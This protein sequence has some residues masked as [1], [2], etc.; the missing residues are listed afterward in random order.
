MAGELCRPEVS[1]QAGAG[2]ANLS[3]ALR[4]TPEIGQLL[5]AQ[6][7]PPPEAVNHTEPLRARDALV[8]HVPTAP[9]APQKG[10]QVKA[11]EAVDCLRQLALKGQATHLAVSDYG[12]TRLLLQKNG[13]VHGAVL[14]LFEVAAGY[15]A[16]GQLLT[17][18]QQIRRTQQTTDNVRL[19]V[20]HRALL[21][22]WC[23]SV[24]FA[25]ES[26]FLFDVVSWCSPPPV[27]TSSEAEPRW[28]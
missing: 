22:P 10:V 4:A 26:L 6:T 21:D 24:K 11:A 1:P 23:S 13:L 15:G 20:D 16:P 5:G 17:S 3:D 2:Q 9:V 8:V 18:L 12:K 27:S 14:D 19:S 7:T 25:I 28:H